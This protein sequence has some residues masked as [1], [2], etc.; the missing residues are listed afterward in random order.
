MRNNTMKKNLRM[1]FGVISLIVLCSLMVVLTA[2]SVTQTQL[3]AENSSVQPAPVPDDTS[4]TRE[5]I[6]KLI[7]EKLAPS[8][9]ETVEDEDLR[10]AITGKWEEKIDDLVGKTRKEV[11]ES[12][13]EDVKAEVTDTGTTD[14]LW[15]NWS[16]E[17][18]NENET[19]ESEVDGAGGAPNRD[20]KRFNKIKKIAMP[21]KTWTFNTTAGP[22]TFWYDGTGGHAE[23][24]PNNKIGNASVAWIQ[25]VRSGG[26]TRW[27]S[28]A[29]DVNTL[30][31]ND[32]NFVTRTDAVYGFRV[33][34]TKGENTPFYDQ[35]VLKSGETLAGYKLG[36]DITSRTA[37]AGGTMEFS[38]NPGLSSGIE[39]MSAADKK[40]D[41]YRFYFLLSPMNTATGEIYGTVE[42]G[43]VGRKGLPMQ[44]IEPSLI[45]TAIP[46]LKGRD[47]AFDR[48]NTV[49]T[50]Q[51]LTWPPHP[52]CRLCGNVV[53]PVPGKGKFWMK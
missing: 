53:Y 52:Q 24:K 33:D 5:E 19:D 7:E 44:G 6:V 29:A 16:A 42:W 2:S 30:S 40:N 43:L 51:F 31:K 27:Y 4:M 13:F 12:L 15:E 8:L 50:K 23:F 11:I 45:T 17:E 18:T 48:W 3:A 20:M 14:K 1:K 46:E 34:R 22:I 36:F 28:S 38:D 10:A 25:V 9:L 21:S 41:E 49:F 39:R 35:S 26:K 32:L 37:K 47:L